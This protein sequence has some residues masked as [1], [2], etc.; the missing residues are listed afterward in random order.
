MNHNAESRYSGAER[1]IERLVN[2]IDRVI[3]REEP[4]QRRELRMLAS[5]LI[6][7]NTSST[8]T[9]EDDR[10]MPRSMGIFAGGLGLLI[11]GGG[12]FVLLPPIALLMLLLGIAAM[13][14]GGIASLLKKSTDRE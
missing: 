9:T 8:E 1:E 10:R 6:S 13:I 7:Q 3:E 4:D 5:S 11:V 14:W 12:L 2:E